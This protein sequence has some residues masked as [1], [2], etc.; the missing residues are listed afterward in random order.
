MPV[1]LVLVPAA[2][3]DLV[4]LGWLRDSDL[5]DREAVKEAFIGCL[6]SSPGFCDIGNAGGAAPEFLVDCPAQ[7]AQTPHA[8][9]VEDARH[10]PGSHPALF[11]STLPR[12]LALARVGQ[13]TALMAREDAAAEVQLRPLRPQHWPSPASSVHRNHISDAVLVAPKVRCGAGAAIGCQRLTLAR[14]LVNL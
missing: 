12:A 7:K 2:I 5:A 14:P 6:R 4:R 10:A 13:P 8:Y 11:E 1:Q 3:R 9:G